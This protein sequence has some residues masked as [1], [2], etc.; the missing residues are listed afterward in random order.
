MLGFWDVS[1]FCYLFIHSPFNSLH[2]DS[3]SCQRMKTSPLSLNI[4]LF[5]VNHHTS[6]RH[7][8]WSFKA[9]THCMSRKSTVLVYM[10]SS[11]DNFPFLCLLIF[12]TIPS[13]PPPTVHPV[14]YVSG[15]YTCC[16]CYYIFQSFSVCRKVQTFGI[17]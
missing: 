11:T 16:L 4:F 17:H 13:L 12:F 8:M 2:L 14:P 15:I 9:Y 6:L 10:S 7:T 1:N 5:T 3:A